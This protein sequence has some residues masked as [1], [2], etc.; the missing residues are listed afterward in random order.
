LE[1]WAPLFQ[2]KLDQWKLTPS[3]K[4]LIKLRYQGPLL[5]LD[6]SRIAVTA[7]L[8]DA[9]LAKSSPDIMVDH[10]SGMVAYE[11]Q[12]IRW[13][14]LSGIFHNERLTFNGKLTGLPDQPALETRMNSSPLTL[15]TQLH[16]AAGQILIDSLK[17]SFHDSVFDVTGTLLLE[18]A[19]PSVDI[20]G[21][22]DLEL[23]DLGRLHPT[24][25][26]SLNSLEAQGQI[27]I[28]G[29]FSGHPKEWTASAIELKATDGHL[30][31]GGLPLEL[32]R[33]SYVQNPQGKGQGELTGR[34]LEGNLSLACTLATND[35][36][37]P[38]SFTGQITDADLSKIAHTKKWQDKNIGGYLSS[39]I[40]FSGPL[41]ATEKISGKGDL[42]I[43]KGEIAQIQLLKGIWKLLSIEEFGTIIFHEVKIPRL[44]IK[45][46][47]LLTNACL[48]ESP[49]LVVRAQG[50]IDIHQNIDLLITPRFLESAIVASQAD[51]LRKVPSALLS[52]FA[53]EA[54]GVKITG[55]L[56]EHRTE[57]VFF[58][59][60]VLNNTKNFLLD[61]LWGVGEEILGGAGKILE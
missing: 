60:K 36:A 14:D 55:T 48:M 43:Q 9:K 37:L 12:H 34:L 54:L 13:E 58:S 61:T 16:M 6:V 57:K 59:D 17:G 39:N 51:I 49:A 45:D 35:P 41:T 29:K 20:S 47:K 7:Y 21:R 5:P 50:W 10:I 32:S 40:T 33:L 53:N 25:A 22:V 23:A 19:G 44:Y 27:L 4:A 28:T 24:M 8:Q 56:K 15:S 26:N 31:L 2:E 18:N 46:N 30:T 52:N 3:G 42:F 1:T 11:A 38:I